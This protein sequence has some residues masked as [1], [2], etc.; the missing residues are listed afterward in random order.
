[1]KKH[2]LLFL[3]LILS[4]PAFSCMNELEVISGITRTKINA[5][6][7]KKPAVNRIRLQSYIIDAQ[8]N[9]GE[10]GTCSDL[11]IAYLYLGDFK[12][13]LALS[14]RLVAKFSRKYEVVMTH[15]AALELNGEFAEA[16]KFL[17]KGIKINPS[18]H[19]NSEWIHVKILEDRISGKGTTILDLDFG[20]GPHP[21]VPANTDLRKT[22]EQLQFQLMERYYFIPKNDPQFGALLHDYADLLYLNNFKTISNDFYRMAARYG[23]VP[24]AKRELYQKPET[25]S[26]VVTSGPPT[27]VKQDK[28]GSGLA[29]IVLFTVTGLTAL[30]LL[31]LLRKK[32][33][34]EL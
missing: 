12:S 4:I 26:A 33:K 1:M 25:A 7:L 27:K 31:R 17:R 13:A 14:T 11:V 9:C 16:L 19:N 24:V 20:K 6:E 34:R 15:A 23:H 21:E 8:K 28:Q 18:S 29:I 32:K 2:L 10:K 3:L 30:L 22:M 5:W